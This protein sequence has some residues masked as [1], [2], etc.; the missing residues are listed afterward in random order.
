MIFQSSILQKFSETD[1]FRHHTLIQSFPFWTTFAPPTLS[2]MAYFQAHT[3]NFRETFRFF[4]RNMLQKYNNFMIFANFFEGKF[5][6]YFFV[7]YS[8][9]FSLFGTFFLAQKKYGCNI[10][11]LQPKV[12]LFIYSRLRLYSARGYVLCPSF[13]PSVCALFPAVGSLLVH[14]GATCRG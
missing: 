13:V 12:R 11:Q 1:N 2:H 14:G 9:Q 4:S 10:K 6:Y 5:F 7:I 3:K 8:T